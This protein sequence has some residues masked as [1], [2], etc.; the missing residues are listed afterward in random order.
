MYSQVFIVCHQ[1]LMVWGESSLVVGLDEKTT[2]CMF[3]I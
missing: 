1:T 2:C 3:I